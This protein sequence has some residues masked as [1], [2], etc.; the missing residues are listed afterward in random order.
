MPDVAA[1]AWRLQAKVPDGIF[2]LAIEASDDV[3]HAEHE[4]FADRCLPYLAGGHDDPQQV[5]LGIISQ[6]AG[7]RQAAAGAGLGYLG[8]LAEVRDSR[9]VLLMLGIAATPLA[10]PEGID[11][12][13]LL[14]TML[15]HQYPD[16]HVEDFATSTGVG[17]GLQHVRDQ[18]LDGARP[19]NALPGTEPA[20]LTTGIAQA[21]VP[22]PEAGLLGMAVGLSLTAD[23][24]DLA[25]IF[26]ATIAYHMTV[27]PQPP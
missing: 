25:T 22:F 8:A 14:A 7:L 27:G 15:R 4:A 6:L 9:P 18:I 21:L 12:A 10:L 26:A 24:I 23:D 11:P 17:V 1:G 16:A 13:G 3:A 19:G 2:T 20:T 5:R